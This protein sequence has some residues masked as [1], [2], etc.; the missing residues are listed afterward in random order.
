MSRQ[1]LRTQA[2]QYIQQSLGRPPIDN[3]SP[4]SSSVIPLDD[5]VRLKNG[6]TNPPQAMM[7]A[8]RQLYSDRARQAEIDAR[9]VIPF[10]EK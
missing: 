6:A 4:G 1:E 7:A 3:G 10:Q 2:Y 5:L 9:L 8:L